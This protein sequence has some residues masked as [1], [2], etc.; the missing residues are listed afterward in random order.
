MIGYALTGVISF[1]V[2]LFFFANIMFLEKAIKSL[3][4]WVYWMLFPIAIAFYILDVAWNVFFGSLFFL[5]FPHESRPTLTERMRHLLITDDGWRFKLAFFMCKYL[6]EP[7][8]PNHCGLR[9]L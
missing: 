9:D 2:L 8:D 7:W 3:P 4:R 1:F 6:V 5:Q